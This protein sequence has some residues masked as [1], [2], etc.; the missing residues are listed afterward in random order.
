MTQCR[1]Y[2]NLLH[3]N[4]KDISKEE[5]LDMA[6][7]VDPDIGALLLFSFMQAA[8]F[9]VV[10]RH[11]AKKGEVV[12]VSRRNFYRKRNRYIHDIEQ[13]LAVAGRA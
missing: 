4:C 13:R 5:L 6:N 10:E 7:N 3:D 2:V 12:P 9:E 1:S 8:S 11:E